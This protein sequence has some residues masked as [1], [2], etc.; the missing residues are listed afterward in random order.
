MV[1]VGGCPF[2]GKTG[3]IKDSLYEQRGNLIFVWVFPFFNKINGCSGFVENDL[4]LV[5]K[6]IKEFGIV[7]FM[8]KT[9][10]SKD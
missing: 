3:I 6:E 5:K 9:S 10:I 2:L 4:E 7:N 1:V 8:R